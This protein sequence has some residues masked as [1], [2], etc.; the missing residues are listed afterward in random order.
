[1]YFVAVFAEFLAPQGPGAYTARYTYAP[2]QQFH[3]WD[4]TGF[5]LH[6]NGYKVR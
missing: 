2:P 5:K 3:F 6:V 4:E 1:M